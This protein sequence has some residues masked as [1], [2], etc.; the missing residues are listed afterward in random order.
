V[1]RWENS[2]ATYDTRGLLKLMARDFSLTKG[3]IPFVVGFSLLGVFL[4]AFAG[5]DFYHW[6]FTGNLYL[7]FRHNH[8]AYTSYREVPGR[9]VVAVLAN[10]RVVVAGIVAIVAACTAPSYFRMKERARLAANEAQPP[11]PP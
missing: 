4:L 5:S 2:I 6:Y 8:G 9:F 3:T 7:P 11:H 1:Q 10:L